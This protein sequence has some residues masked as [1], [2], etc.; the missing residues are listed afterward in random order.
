MVQAR[1]IRLRRNTMFPDLGMEYLAVARVSRIVLVCA[2]PGC[3]VHYPL[4]L[5]QGLERLQ[6]G[7][8]YTTTLAKKNNAGLFFIQGQA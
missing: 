4:A 5:V 2:G 7:G 1:N 3:D 8:R 6:V